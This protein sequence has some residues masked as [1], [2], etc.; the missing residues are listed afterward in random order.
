MSTSEPVRRTAP[1]TLELIAQDAA[2]V[3]VAADI[4]AAR[5][6]LCQALELGGLT[7]SAGT[8]RA[9]VAT[10]QACDVEVHAL[11]RPRA[12]GFVFS[13]ADIAVMLSDIEAAVTAGADGVVIGC[14]TAEG[15]INEDHMARLRDRAG[16][17]QVS[18]HRAVDVS[19]DPI[20]AVEAVRGLGLSRVLTSGGGASVD[21][22]L[23][24]L[25]TMI[26][27]VDG[28]LEI[29][30][31]GGVT[32]QNAPRLVALGVDAIHFSAKRTVLGHSP[33]SLGSAEGAGDAGRYETVD[34]AL[35][36]MIAEAALGRHS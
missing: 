21:A 23:G 25:A 24:A 35:A 34:P 9:A 13:E 2:A 30:A 27:R 17:A 3:R 1:V 29:M 4:G 19:A 5:V 15:H 6:E 22:G 7:A 20:R 16:T 26:D 31:G 33:V 8:L 32:A 18:A 11:I 14:L 10:G 36:R 12:G 28:D